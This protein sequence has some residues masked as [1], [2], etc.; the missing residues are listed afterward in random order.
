MIWADQGK[1]LRLSAIRADYQT[2]GSPTRCSLPTV[3]ACRAIL[4][5]ALEWIKAEA[6]TG[7]RAVISVYCV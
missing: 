2:T 6:S 1:I 5:F 4:R 7:V 3:F